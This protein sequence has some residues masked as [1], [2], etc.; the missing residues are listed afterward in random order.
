MTARSDRPIKR[1]GRAAPLASRSLLNRGEEKANRNDDPRRLR[2]GRVCGPRYFV[3]FPAREYL[4]PNRKTPELET[5]LSHSKQ[6]MATRSNRNFSRVLPESQIPIGTQ[7]EQGGGKALATEASDAKAANRNSAQSEIPSKPMKVRRHDIF[8]TATADPTRIGI[9]RDQR[10]P[11]EL[12]SNHARK[13]IRGIKAKKS[14]SQENPL[15]R[16]AE[17]SARSNETLP[18]TTI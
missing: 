12:S 14:R 15:F 13:P 11:R 6:T 8:L 9:P 1:Q 3:P 7:L 16:C 4:K 17:I 10:E 18:F 2:P 5:P